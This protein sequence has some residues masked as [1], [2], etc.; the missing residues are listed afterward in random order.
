LARTGHGRAFAH[1]NAVAE[2]RVRLSHGPLVGGLSAKLRLIVATIATVRIAVGG[3]TA[4][5]GAR[6]AVIAGPIAT[7]CLGARKTSCLAARKTSLSFDP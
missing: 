7:F 5:I 3:R 6:T 2:P 4:V 1:Q